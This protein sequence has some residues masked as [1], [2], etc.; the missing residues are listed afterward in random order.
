MVVIQ[1]RKS[2]SDSPLLFGAFFRVS[3]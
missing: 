3:E 1:R 2:S